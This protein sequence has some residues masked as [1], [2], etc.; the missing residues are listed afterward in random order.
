MEKKFNIQKYISFPFKLYSY[1]TYF[2][3]TE[4]HRFIVIAIS[5]AKIVT[6]LEISSWVFRSQWFWREE[7]EREKTLISCFVFAQVMTILS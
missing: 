6:E 4:V 7:K 1:K 5:F 2:G 3:F